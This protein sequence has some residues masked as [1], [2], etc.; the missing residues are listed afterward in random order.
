[1]NNPFGEINRWTVLF[2]GEKIGEKVNFLPNMN[3]PFTLNGVHYLVYI[4]NYA[5]HTIVAVKNPNIEKDK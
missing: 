3:T 2:N 1:M 5:K 4:A